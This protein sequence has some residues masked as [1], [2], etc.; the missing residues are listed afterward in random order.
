[1]N[2]PILNQAPPVIQKK[3]D[4]QDVGV[5]AGKERKIK[6]RE[7]GVQ[8]ATEREGKVAVEREGG[9]IRTQEGDE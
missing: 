6:R 1:M 9:V 7:G 3:K 2:L 8:A 5:G 4:D